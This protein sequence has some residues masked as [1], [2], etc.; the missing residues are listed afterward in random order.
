ML[1]KNNVPGAGTG[2][3]AAARDSKRRSSPQPGPIHTTRKC[4]FPKVRKIGSKG[5]V[6]AVIWTYLMC[7]TYATYVYH[8]Y[9][10]T[11]QD[12]HA[13]V[14]GLLTCSFLLLGPFAGLYASCRFGR[15]RVVYRGLWL[16]WSGTFVT[17]SILL[18]QNL[19]GIL[20]QQ[21]ET[22]HVHT[23]LSYFEVVTFAAYSVGFMA[24]S[25]NIVPFGL[26]QKPDA[27]D[28]QTAAFIHWIV[29]SLLSAIAT[30]QLLISFCEF[31]LALVVES[32]VFAVLLTLALCSTSLLP[33]SLIIEPEGNNPL[34]SILSV[35]WFAVKHKTPVCKSDCKGKAPSWIDLGKSQ[36]GGPFTNEEVE[37]VRTCFR[38]CITIISPTIAL[39]FVHTYI[40]LLLEMVQCVTLTIDF[41]N[42]P[43][44]VFIVPCI[45]SLV[46][47][48]PLH[49]AALCP[50]ISSW[51]PHT[52]K[53]IGLL[54]GCTVFV[55]LTLLLESGALYI[56][57][58]SF[59]S[60]L[61]G[62][63]WIH[64]ATIMFVYYQ[65]MT[66]SLMAGLEFVWAKAPYNLRGLLVGL[67]YAV[68]L[69]SPALGN[70]IYTAWQFEN[71]DSTTILQLNLLSLI[72]TI[73][74]VFVWVTVARWY[75][76]IRERHETQEVKIV[77][78]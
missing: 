20:L 28:E 60:K 24:F 41:T 3:D 64:I 70:G 75:K 65:F 67:E 7:T 23:I 8:W 62:I 19:A 26:E 51:I 72:V 76:K 50:L 15:Y 1:Y 10:T 18:Q 34:T 25:V 12:T 29:W 55:S 40:L 27:S 6:L 21:N 74:G 38:M 52:N 69:F 46:L 54:H 30:S 68:W 71:R 57:P 59:D 47:Q 2:E 53:R 22:V 35:L 9:S 44:G 63:A 66:I 48:L 39:C 58:L 56:M 78:A 13:S 17:T 43:N 33:G 14:V 11:F 4:S 73:L 49:D 5:A 32:V 16:M 61:N 31:R 45:L 42:Q 36:H 77:E 37:D